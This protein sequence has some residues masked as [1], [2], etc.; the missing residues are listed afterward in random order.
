MATLRKT[1]VVWATGAGGPGVSNFYSA[2]GDDVTVV[3]ATFF[4]AIKGAFPPAVSWTIPVSGD[5]LD[6]VT[7]GITGAWIGGTGA[8]ISGSATATYFAGTG[9]MVR[10][11]TGSVHN[12]RKV[13]G[14]TFLCPLFNGAGDSDG[15]MGAG[16]LAS[17]QGAATALAATNKLRVW[18]RP[19]TTTSNDG[20]SFAVIGGV[21]PDKTVS[22]RSRRF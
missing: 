15:S 14:R 19:T 16:T 18:H 3:L 8:T 21:V 7:G 13:Y 5:E 22:L 12:R 17:L 9:G 4:N 10:W 6:D 11:V 20:V 1:Q 2:F